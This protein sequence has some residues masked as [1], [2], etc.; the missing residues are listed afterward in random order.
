MPCSL[1]VTLTN[2][3]QTMDKHEK[4]LEGLEKL[5]VILAEQLL[6]RVIASVHLSSTLVELDTRLT[7]IEVRQ[8]VVTVN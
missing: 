6:E 7:A 5:V 4:R 2:W 8:G 1:K 3:S